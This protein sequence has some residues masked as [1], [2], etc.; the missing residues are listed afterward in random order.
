[1][2]D[3]HAHVYSEQFDKDTNEMLARAKVQGVTKI[4]MPAIDSETHPA[5]MDLAREHPDFCF[6]MIGLHP[7]SVKENFMEEINIV[8][9]YLQEHKFYGIGETGIDLYWDK[10]FYNQ[11]IE[12]LEIQAELA[13]EHNLPLILHTR[14]ATQET[15]DVIQQYKGRGLRGIFHCFGGTVE[16]AEQIIEAGFLLGIG[17]VVSFKNGGLQQV[18][19]HCDIQHIVLETDAP[20]LAPT[21]FRGK[22]NEPAYLTQITECIATIM[23]IDKEQVKN[24]TTKNAGDLFQLR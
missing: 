23:Q 12:A 22:R 16:E 2:I 10:T 17:G 3:S 24:I 20:Y 14:N 15:I 9:E 11:Q 21:P 18:L 19:A 6:P 1:M 4:F 13:I 7:C 8:K 5:M